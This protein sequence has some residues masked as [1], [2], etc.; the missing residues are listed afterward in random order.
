MSS[1]CEFLREAMVM[2]DFN[3]ENVLHLIGVVI[4]KHYVVLPFMENKDL[5]SF[6]SAP[7]RV[8]QQFDLQ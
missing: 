5:R 6:I 7:E 3:H 8:S 1:I 2:K 4:E